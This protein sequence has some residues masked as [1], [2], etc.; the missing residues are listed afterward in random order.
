MIEKNNMG[1]G[2]EIHYFKCQLFDELG[3]FYVKKKMLV[4]EYFL[5]KIERFI[6]LEK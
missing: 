4:K 1:R 5:R 6:D 2:L 3:K